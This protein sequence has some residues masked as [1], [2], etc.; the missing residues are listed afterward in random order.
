VH[1][2]MRRSFWNVK[3]PQDCSWNWRKLLR[4]RHLA[5]GFLKFEVG[6]GTSITYGM[7]TGIHVGLYLR[8]SASE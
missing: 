2:L 3:L 7:I 8:D 1:L 6:D 4:I 5:R